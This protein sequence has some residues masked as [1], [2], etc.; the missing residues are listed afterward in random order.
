MCL[1]SGAVWEPWNT[2]AHVRIGAPE[3]ASPSS[4]YSPTVD[5]RTAS[6]FLR[7]LYR[8]SVTFVTKAV[9]KAVKSWNQAI[10]LQMDCLD[11]VNRRAV[12][13]RATFFFLLALVAPARED[14]LRLLKN[15]SCG[16]AYCGSYGCRVMRDAVNGFWM[17][18]P[19]GFVRMLSSLSIIIEAARPGSI[20]HSTFHTWEPNNTKYSPHLGVHTAQVIRH[21][22]LFV[23]TLLRHQT[24]CMSPFFL[25]HD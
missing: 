24:I 4:R 8:Q 2:R 5:V 11:A 7:L 12:C 10:P 22:R 19:L 9:E 23:P 15:D 17:P 18:D 13:S 3:H 25:P 6:P 14:V 21:T 1:F 20:V 16:H